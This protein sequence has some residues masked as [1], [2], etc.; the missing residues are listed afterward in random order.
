[1]KGWLKSLVLLWIS[2]GD[3]S[4]LQRHTCDGRSCCFHQFKTFHRQE[5]QLF[6]KTFKE[7]WTGSYRMGVRSCTKQ[8][9]SCGFG[10][11]SVQWWGVGWSIG[12]WVSYTLCLCE[13][14]VNQQLK[15]NVQRENAG[16]VIV[17]FSPDDLSSLVCQCYYR[18]CT[19]LEMHWWVFL[20]SDTDTDYL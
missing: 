5:S 6:R 10:S 17:F 2:T 14:K 13:N 3:H 11:C 12:S 20:G 1:M 18:K 8:M 9:S 19:Q 4:V 16:F 7:S 15:K